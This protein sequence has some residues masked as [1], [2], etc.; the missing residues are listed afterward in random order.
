MSPE[1][2]ITSPGAAH[3]RADYNAVRPPAGLDGMTPKAFAQNADK[4]Y[5]N[6]QNLT[7]NRRHV[8]GQDHGRLWRN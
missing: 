5:I 6:P 1:Y 4:A 7:Q 3:W 2:G 8:R